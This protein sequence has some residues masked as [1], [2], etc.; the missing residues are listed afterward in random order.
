MNRDSV[1]KI[2]GEIEKALIRLKEIKKVSLTDFL[3]NIDLQDI[4]KWNFY[5]LVQGCLDLGNHLVAK[6]KLGIP[7]TYEEIFVL[8]KDAGIV[9]ESMEDI[10][11]KMASFRNR[12]AHAYFKL[13]PNLL[14]DYLKNLERVEK[15]VSKIQEEIE[16][17]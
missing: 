4:A 13:D 7:Q 14:Y 12:L 16:A 3:K 1:Y 11:L 6:K 2:I 8:L 9:E 17:E 10:L 5:I 15:F